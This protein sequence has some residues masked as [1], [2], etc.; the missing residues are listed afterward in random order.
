MREQ[1]VPVSIQVLPYDPRW[2]EWFR[3]IRNQLWAQ[4]SD[5]ALDVVHVGSTSIEGMAAKPIIDID[6][7]VPDMGDLD[8]IV[9][10]LSRIGY[11]HQ[12]DLGI[13]GREAF[14]LDYK[15]KYSHNLYLVAVGSTAYRN[16]VFL[17]KHL[18]ENPEAFRRYKDLKVGLAESSESIEEFMQSKTLLILEFLEAEGMPRDELDS[19]RGDNL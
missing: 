12:G 5:L 6:I 1:P 13:R 2:R 19:I 3:E 8:E 16:H 4:V 15:H 10:R 7:V 18:T 17:K 14:G 9:S 11:V